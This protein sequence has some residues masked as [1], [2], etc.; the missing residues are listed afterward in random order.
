VKTDKFNINKILKDAEDGFSSDTTMSPSM[1]AIVQL[2][3]FVIK[4]LMV[5]F[6]LTSRNSSKPPSQD[7][8]R[9]KKKKA[10]SGNKPGAQ[11]GHDGSRL[12][13]VANPDKIEVIKIDRRK[14][15]KGSYTSAGFDKRQVVDIEITRI[16]TE[17]QA[18][19]LKDAKGKQYVATFPKGVL[20]DIQYGAKL[21]AHAVYLSLYQLMPYNRVAD[22]FQHE[23]NVPVSMGSLYNFNQ[24]AFNLLEH[25]ETISKKHLL[26]AKVLHADETGINISGKRKW[27]HTL[28]SSL[29]TFCYP[30]D[31]RGHKAMDEMAVLPKYKGVLCHDYWKAYYRYDCEHSLCGA[32][33]LRELTW[34]HEEDNQEWALDLKELLQ[35]INK[36]LDSSKFKISERKTQFY[37][38]KY[39]EI[40]SEGDKSCPIEER[41]KSQKRGR[42]KQTKSR[43]LINRLIQRE[44]EI[45]LFLIK[46]GVPF[47]N[48]QGER[49]LRMTKVQQKISGCFRSVDGAQIFCRVRSYL[50]S[51]Q[52]HSVGAADALK[53][54]FDGRLPD[55]VN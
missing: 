41:G 18:E 30:H 25:F 9:E 33:L 4:T 47:T 16:I 11:K 27:L 55:F 40:L 50:I 28:S 43:N 34:S 31:Q 35:E 23:I 37:L 26:K 54:L 22:Y 24:E 39:R 10:K 13:P 48:N 49:D 21:K 36:Y 14:L 5:R 17:Y 44:T 38:K 7:P 15:P 3:I 51:C 12:S 45:L 32:H 46:P 29:W 1:R 53:L 6:N 42:V 2:L 19:R 8:N 20:T 52:K